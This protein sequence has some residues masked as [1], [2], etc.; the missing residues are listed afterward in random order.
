MSRHYYD[1]F[2]L[3]QSSVLDRALGNIDL[4]ERVATHKSI[5]FKAPWA[6]YDQARPGTL[7]LLPSG[8]IVD[9]LKRDYN[10]MQ[11]MFFGDAPTFEAIVDH[12]KDLETRI[13][14]A[15]L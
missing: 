11:P 10:D 3:S 13:N 7:R 9:S 4:L 12:L 2:C 15:E 1:V 14:T 8:R 5:Y 6:R